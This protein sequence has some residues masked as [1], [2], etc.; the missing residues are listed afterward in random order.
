MCVCV[1][2]LFVCVCVCLCMRYTTTWLARFRQTIS[3]ST[4]AFPSTFA[5]G[6]VT[7]MAFK[8]SIMYLYRNF[9]I[10]FVLVSFPIQKFNYPLSAPHTPPHLKFIHTSIQIYTFVSVCNNNNSNENVIIVMIIISNATS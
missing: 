8:I 2:V 4:L 1:C 9:K 6:L 5:R 3:T 10:P 7:C